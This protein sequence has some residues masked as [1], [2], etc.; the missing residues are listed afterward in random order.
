MTEFNRKYHI[1]C[2]GFYSVFNV[3]ENDLVRMVYGNMEISCGFVAP[4]ILA[5]IG[6]IVMLNHKMPSMNYMIETVKWIA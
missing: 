4:K 3:T 1:S 5:T 6:C 2:R